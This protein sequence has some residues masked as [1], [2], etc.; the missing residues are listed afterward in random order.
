MPPYYIDSRF[1]DAAIIAAKI[2]ALLCNYYWIV[3]FARRDGRAISF[4]LFFSS[5][6]LTSISANVAPWYVPNMTLMA[7]VVI[8]LISQQ[9][10]ANLSIWENQADS[11]KL[12]SLKWLFHASGICALLLTSALTAAAAYQVKLQQEILEDGHRKQIGLWLRDNASTPKDTVF[13]E[14]LGYVG[15]FSQLKMLDWPGL[16]SPEVVAASKKLNSNDYALLIDYLKPDW[17]VLRPNEVAYLE[18]KMPELLAAKYREVKL[19]D[20]SDKIAAHAFL[21]DR[22]G[23][24]YDQT[25]IVYRR[26]TPS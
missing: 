23:F 17:L 13:V 8:G 12:K 24:L 1:P 2:P 18:Q 7:I 16:S 22:N 9:I 21:P 10:A 3:P 6:Y 25:F 4:G 14:C 20:V 15:F 5:F 26:T 19:F 11:N